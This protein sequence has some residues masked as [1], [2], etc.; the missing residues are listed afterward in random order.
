MKIKNPLKEAIENKR[1][2]KRAKE[3]KDELEWMKKPIL[4]FKAYCEFFLGDFNECLDT[5]EQ[6]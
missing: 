4:L 3:E 6:Y 2:E 5:Y 1:E